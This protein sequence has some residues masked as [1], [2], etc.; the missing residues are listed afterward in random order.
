M[1]RICRHSIALLCYLLAMAGAI[2]FALF[3]LLVGTG[4]WSFAPWLSSGP[5][6]VVDLVWLAVFGLQHSGMARQGFKRIWTRFVPVTLERSVYAALSGVVLLA[7]PIIWQPLP[8]K[9]L[10]RLPLVVVIVPLLAGVGLALINARYDHAG[11]FGLRQAWG[12]VE[13]A[14]ELIVTGPYRYVR[15]PLMASLLVF[16]WTHPIMKPELALLAAGLSVYILI[17]IVLE[18]RDLQGRFA[19]RYVAYR[20]RVPMLIPWRA[21]FQ[22][23]TR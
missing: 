20:R 3:V 21:G 17:G 11:L 4:L 23:E 1:V 22:E 6:W 18:E 5:A 19:S 2:V 9:P 8:G 7:L 14:E 10:W 13:E 12:K 16:L 15:H